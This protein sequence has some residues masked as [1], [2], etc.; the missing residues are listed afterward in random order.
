MNCDYAHH[1]AP[2]SAAECSHTFTQRQPG[3]RFY[4]ATDTEMDIWPVICSQLEKSGF[5]FMSSFAMGLAWLLLLFSSPITS[6][7]HGVASGSLFTCLLD[8]HRPP[9]DAGVWG[10]SLNPAAML[11]VFVRQP[12][13]LQVTPK[14]IYSTKPRFP[15]PLKCCGS[16]Q[17]LA[18]CFLLGMGFFLVFWML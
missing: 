7:F 5:S 8:H 2:A 11:L 1:V 15:P 14:N 18:L 16:G 3:L 13:H 4:I 10:T 17:V 12:P 6:C 9:R